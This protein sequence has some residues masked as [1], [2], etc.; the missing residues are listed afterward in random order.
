VKAL[1]VGCGRTKAAGA[2]GID[3]E[4]HPGVDVV[5]DLDRF[6]Y[7][8]ADGE[9]DRIVASHSLEHLA[10]VVRVLEELHRIAAPGAVVEIEVPHFSSCDAYTDVT[11]RHFFGY[12]SFDYFT[13]AGLY[14]VHRYRKGRYEIAARHINFW[15]LRGDSRIVPHRLLGIEWLANRHPTFYEKFLAFVFPARSLS[16]R[17]VPVKP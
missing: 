16:V 17:L 10:D 3:I 14:G 7:P 5:H 4:P 12:R 13:E 8:F 1:D 6:P 11:H 9:F 2:I 15:P